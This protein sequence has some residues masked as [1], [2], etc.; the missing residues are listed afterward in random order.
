MNRVF[1]FSPTTQHIQISLTALGL[2]G[3][4][5]LFLPFAYGE[6]PIGYFY[7]YAWWSDPPAE[8]GAFLQWFFG[9]A[10]V[11]PCIIPP[12]PVGIGYAFW[13][14]T[15]RLPGWFTSA[16]YLLAVLL[17]CLFLAAVSYGYLTEDVIYLED[18]ILAGLLC[19]SMA[20]AVW[21]FIQGVSHESPVRGL[22]AMQSVYVATAAWWL[23]DVYALDHFQSGAWLGAI[24]LLTYLAQVTLAVKRFIWILAIIGPQV[25]YVIYDFLF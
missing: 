20:G 3:I 5:L 12:V 19:G 18:L 24:T 23:F 2:S 17:A 13:L 6:V 22:V 7:L 8:S 21:L 15:G 1:L 16:S 14:I 4:A 9:L 10:F 25:I 11:Q